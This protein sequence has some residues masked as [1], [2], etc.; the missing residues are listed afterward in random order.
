MI[1]D[2]KACFYFVSQFKLYKRSLIKLKREFVSDHIMFHLAA[3]ILPGLKE[4]KENFENKKLDRF[5]NK[6]HFLYN[7]L[8]I[9]G[10]SLTW[11]QS[12]TFFFA[13]DRKQT[14]LGKTEQF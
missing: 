13:S 5:T 7:S 4:K 11:W 8:T 10:N 3:P 12:E 2:L 1:D 9:C 6:D 14:T